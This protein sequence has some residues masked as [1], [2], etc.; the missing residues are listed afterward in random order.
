[1]SFVRTVLGD[2]PP[3]S[4]GTCLSH[5]HLIIDPSYVTQ[6]SPDLRLPSVE[7]A[8]RELLAVRAAGGRAAVDCMPC[9]AGRNILKLA[10]I[11]R[12]SGL[13][14]IAA[15][16]LHR[17]RYYPEGHWRYRLTPEELATA[18]G[19]LADEALWLDGRTSA[20]A[21]ASA[22]KR[23]EQLAQDSEAA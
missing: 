10:E 18:R 1:M 5:E 3:E 19:L 11:S 17:T 16:G 20:G 6:L 8:V 14:V 7:N 2:I 13:H 12:Q 15:T 4:L 22:V 21:Q 9:D 23:N